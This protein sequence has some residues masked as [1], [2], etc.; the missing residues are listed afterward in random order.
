VESAKG[1]RIKLKEEL[2]MR[3]KIMTKAES[4]KEDDYESGKVQISKLVAYIRRRDPDSKSPPGPK[5]KV[6]LLLMTCIL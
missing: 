6:V 3:K 5:K 1:R 2:L 4:R